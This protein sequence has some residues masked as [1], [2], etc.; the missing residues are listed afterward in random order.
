[1][2]QLIFIPSLL[3]IFQ[4]LY[5]QEFNLQNEHGQKTGKWIE[6][7]ESGMIK[8]ITHYTPIG[9]EIANEYDT[10]ILPKTNDT[11][12]YIDI[13]KTNRKIAFQYG[14]LNYDGNI[15]DLPAKRD[16]IEKYEYND[17]WSFKRILKTDSN[18]NSIY[19]YGLEK[20]IAIDHFDFSV[21]T[22][23]GEY[24]I[25][26]IPLEN[27]CE[28]DISVAFDKLPSN[29]L[30][31]NTNL[32]PANSKYELELKICPEPGKK[33]YS[34]NLNGPNFTITFTIK[35]TGY[36]IKSSVFELEKPIVMAS[37]KIYFERTNS[38]AL[39]TIIK[40]GGTEIKQIPLTYELTEIDLSDLES[41]NYVFTITDF[42]NN[43]KISKII[44][45]Q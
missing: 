7:Y 41:G 13:E 4:Q 37:K 45:L 20:G 17:D 16:W 9:F 43:K 33:E 12:I 32:I 2:K 5:S 27:Q 31:P 1:M 34:I 28:K 23:V 14:L 22:L 39:L 30:A 24:S 44:E 35:S 10:I 26:S 38:E 42:S 15:K 6:Y 3:L 25:I 29:F 11:I 8:E 19:L 18:Y 36:H 21:D 40:K